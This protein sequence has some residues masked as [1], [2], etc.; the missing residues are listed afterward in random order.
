MSP[1]YNPQG[2]K[3]CSI[4][5]VKCRG[6]PSHHCRTQLP[7]LIPLEASRLA[8]GILPLPRCLS[9]RSELSSWKPA[10]G[11]P[12]SAAS[13]AHNA[14]RCNRHWMQ[15]GCCA[16][17]CPARRG[18]HRDFRPVETKKKKRGEWLLTRFAKLCLG[19]NF[20][21]FSTVY[22]LESE[23]SVICYVLALVHKGKM[24]VDMQ[25]H[26]LD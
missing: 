5:N 10:L 21:L 6:L 4:P 2:Y 24:L 14:A 22:L 17:W 12:P 18:L 20:I 15:M 13:P 9:R 16:A 26:R 25:T 11:R 19:I 8:P 1:A 3:G 23:S 7:S